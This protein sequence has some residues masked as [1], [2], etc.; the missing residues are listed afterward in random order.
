MLISVADIRIYRQISTSLAAD[1]INQYIQDAEL[2]DL[3][4]LL[5]EELY[6]DIIADPTATANGNYPALMD[7]STYTFG[8]Y[9]YTHPGIKSVLVDF[10]AARYRFFGSDTD[11]P[12]GTV[13]KQTQDGQNTNYSRNRE[14]YGS[15]RK[16]AKD[17]WDLVKHYLDRMSGD[18]DYTLWFGQAVQIDD[19]QELININKGTLR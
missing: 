8:S 17:R 6:Q 3:R 2:S 4:P 1:K 10:A 15:L 11:T 16:V 7:G 13:I 18:N 19:D 12:F 5:G 9:T 14:V